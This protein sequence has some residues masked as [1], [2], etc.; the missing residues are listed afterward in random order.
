MGRYFRV[1]FRVGAP[2]PPLDFVMTQPSIL[3]VVHSPGKMMRCAWGGAY[4]SVTS[5]ANQLLYYSGHSTGDTIRAARY[6]GILLF[7]KFFVTEIM[8]WTKEEC[9]LIARDME[10]LIEEARA[11]FRAGARRI[12]GD[13]DDDGG[14]RTASRRAEGYLQ[15]RFPWGTTVLTVFQEAVWREGEVETD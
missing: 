2:E 1:T 7:A 13:D 8:T 15:H 4:A 14:T 3:G 10:C 9:V 5:L 6:P 12:R 11:E